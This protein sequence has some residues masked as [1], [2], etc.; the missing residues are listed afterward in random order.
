MVLKYYEILGL[1]QS[2][3]DED[4]KKA[5]KKLALKVHPDKGGCPEKFKE[6][7][8]A[9]DTLKDPQM[10]NRYD[11]INNHEAYI[12]QG[13]N[14]QGNNNNNMHNM[15]NIFSQMFG[16][17]GFANQQHQQTK[18]PDKSIEIQ[19]SLE[20]V[21][22]GCTKNIDVH[23]NYNCFYCKVNCTTCNGVG[24]LNNIIQQGPFTIQQQMPCHICKGVGLI[25]KNLTNCS[26]CS[27]K[28]KYTEIKNIKLDIPI[29]IKNGDKIKFDGLG[30][31]KQKENDISGDLYIIIKVQTHDIF[32]RQ[33][34]K[35]LIY[36][37]CLT[38]KE[39]VIGKRIEIPLFDDIFILETHTLGVIQGDKSYCIKNKGLKGG[40]LICIFNVDYLVLDEDLREKLKNILI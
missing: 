25:Y 39:S 37:T 16:G 10:K 20:E 18:Q 28:S 31:Q 30:E 6:L 24:M 38:W 11:Q 27:G 3:S 12:N 17:G 40:D 19:I 26:K 4:I 23:V 29:N 8:S 2:S 9:Y 15:H 7:Q 32:E 35:N 33:G 36:K 21:Y 13:N 1:S 14:N 22:H 5:Y 34:D